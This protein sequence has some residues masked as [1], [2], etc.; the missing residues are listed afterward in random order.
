[1]SESQISAD[2]TADCGATQLACF[3][4]PNVQAVNPIIVIGP[5]E[6]CS[7]RS[8]EKNISSNTWW[9]SYKIRLSLPPISATLVTAA[10]IWFIA[11]GSAP[12]TTSCPCY[13]CCPAALTVAP[14][15]AYP[16][17]FHALPFFHSMKQLTSL[18]L[19]LGLPLAAAAQAPADTTTIYK[20]QLG[21]T[22]SPVLDGFFR[23][24]RNLPLGLLYKRQVKPNQAIRV[25]LLSQYSRRDTANYPG[26]I[27]TFFPGYREG[28]NNYKV[29]A[30]I[31]LGYEWQK[32]LNRNFVIGYGLETGITYSIYKN[33]IILDFRLDSLQSRN[34][35]VYST[36][37]TTLQLR[38]FSNLQYRVTNKVQIFLESAFMMQYQ[39]RRD[40][41]S[42]QGTFP[43]GSVSSYNK[44]HSTQAF[45][46]PIQ[47]IGVLYHF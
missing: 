9:R 45:F 31:F 13:F 23:N 26:T 46:S 6:Q 22:A 7:L 33:T 44:S 3:P 18:L 19:T 11:P 30:G 20:H 16:G 29:S 42:L 24:N 34:H 37:T 28:T 32:K 41:G 17:L 12:F 15:T 10:R 4:V 43:F 40:D 14:G 21:L 39:S 8:I 35:G 27:T 1:M 25:R 38:P 36:K 2:F 47:L 5:S